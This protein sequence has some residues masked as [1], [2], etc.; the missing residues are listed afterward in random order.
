MAKL[1]D[2]LKNA[3]GAGNTFYIILEGLTDT[4]YIGFEE[5]V[6]CDLQFFLKHHLDITE[7]NPL[8]S[9]WTTLSYCSEL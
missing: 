4:F 8:T 7:A 2:I 1:S 5:S 3:V 9:T 6:H